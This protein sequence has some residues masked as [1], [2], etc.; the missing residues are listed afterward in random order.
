MGAGAAD[1]A[2]VADLRVADA[3]GRFMDD[4]VA[5]GDRGV[6]G[7]ARVGHAAADAQL[8]VLLGDA[9]EPRHVA[10]VDH[11]RRATRGGA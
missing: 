2:P 4:R 6:R 8:T 1:R 11:Q 3:A 7:Q 9:V 5:R 10:D